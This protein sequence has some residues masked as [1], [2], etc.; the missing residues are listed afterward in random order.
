MDEHI[1]E[2]ITEEFQDSYDYV[3]PDEQQ[4]V[5]QNEELLVDNDSDIISDFSD[6]VSS[7]EDV[8]SEDIINI[9]N[10][11]VSSPEVQE[12]TPD[13]TI[14]KTG[15]TY[16]VYNITLNQVEDISEAPEE[17]QIQEE[18]PQ[19]AITENEYSIDDIYNKVDD[20]SSQIAI[21]KSDNY[22]HSKNMEMIGLT[23]VGVC[24][25]ILGG[26]VAYAVF[27]HIRP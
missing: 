26:L 16:N 9:A 13:E 4:E 3:L 19:E 14:E 1:L 20:I 8:N 25:S 12:L 23:V 27:N 22:N 10:D 6:D 11:A 5:L 24:V 7:P 2:F 15:E 18:E 21:I 17:E